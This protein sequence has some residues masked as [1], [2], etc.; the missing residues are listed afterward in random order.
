MPW[1]RRLRQEPTDSGCLLQ[2]VSLENLGLGGVKWL[3]GAP[4]VALGGCVVNPGL[5]R[6]ATVMTANQAERMVEGL[7]PATAGTL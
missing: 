1:R 2:N 3:F 7:G 4:Q 6:R 5:Q